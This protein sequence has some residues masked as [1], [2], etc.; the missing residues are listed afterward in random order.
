MPEN[1]ELNNEELDDSKKIVP[2]EDE[3]EKEKKDIPPFELEYPDNYKLIPLGVMLLAGLPVSIACYIVKYELISFLW[4]LVGS[5]LVF[6]ILG[7]RIRKVV[8]K[9]WYDNALKEYNEKY[10]EVADE[11][12]VIQKDTNETDDDR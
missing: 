6:Y 8:E 9:F 7:R 11:G 1:Q 2:P 4:I 3:L 10:S 12:E 5:L